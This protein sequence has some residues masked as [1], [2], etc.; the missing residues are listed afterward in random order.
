[1]A[2]RALSLALGFL[3]KIAAVIVLASFVLASF[4]AA[5]INPPYHFEVFHT[6][7]G[8]D[9]ANPVG[10]VL[11]DN[12]T[13]MYYG[14]TRNGGSFGL[15]VV[16]KMDI[17]GNE[18]VLHNFAGGADGANPVGAV[19]RDASGNVYGITG[20]GGS[21]LRG[22]L[23]KIDASGSESVLHAFSD[24]PL[25]GP[26][27][28]SAGNLYCTASRAG[29]FGVGAVLMFDSSGQETI[30]YSF[31][32]GPD[33]SYP[34]GTLFRDSVGRLYGT[35]LYGGAFGQGEIF[36]IDTSGNETTLYSFTGGTDGASPVGGLVQDAS[37]NFYGTAP[38]GGNFGLGVIFKLDAQNTFSVLHHFANVLDGEFPSAELTIDTAGRLYGAA[39]GATACGTS[40]CGLV[41]RLETNGTLTPLHFFAGTDGSAPNDLMRA[42]FHDDYGTTSTGGASNLGV[43]YKINSI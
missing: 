30:I 7:T 13:G 21:M 11:R 8:A 17:L 33:G 26:I 32:G 37:G 23:Y 24:S 35:T 6:F 5:V 19:V 29:T 39:Q 25:S 10:Q 27:L 14:A 31:T 42:K 36:E 9:G 1:M 40:T 28:D 34:E 15:G 43:I 38:A 20:A 18:T 41:F 16:Y 12:K 22:T 3:S 4:A 2:Y